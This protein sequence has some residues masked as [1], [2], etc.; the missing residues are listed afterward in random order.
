MTR[1]TRI[2]VLRD[3]RTDEV[4]YVGKTVKTL[5]DRLSG[6]INRSRRIKSPSGSWIKSLAKE[7]LM[8]IIEEIETAG[9]DWAE[10]E[11][12]WI[13]HYRSVTHK[14]TN[15][16]DGGEGVGGVKLKPEHR[17]RLAEIGRARKATNAWKSQMGAHLPEWWTEEI[18]AQKAALVK[19]QMTPE[20]RAAHSDALKE[21]MSSPEWKS[22]H[23][24]AMRTKWT[25]ELRAAQAEKARAANARPDTKAKQLEAAKKRWTPEER[26]KASEATKRTMTPE[27]IARNSATNKARWTPELRA[28]WAERTR[29]QLAEKPIVRTPESLAAAGEKV[30]AAWA[31]KREQKE[32]AGQ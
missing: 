32:Q 28:E 7:G 4:R 31:R 27:V 19:S 15:I 24:V 13:A 26:A 30:R 8:P 1:I 12:Y 3:P 10:R 29:K 2:Y 22:R 21:T 14:L 6:H 17:A 16:C 5:A 20:R 11:R 18:R 23:S 25:P 9:D